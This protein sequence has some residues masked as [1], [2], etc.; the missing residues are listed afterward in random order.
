M[1]YNA[2]FIYENVNLRKMKLYFHLYVQFFYD[3]IQEKEG[4]R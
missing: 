1:V 2:K 3:F 4:T